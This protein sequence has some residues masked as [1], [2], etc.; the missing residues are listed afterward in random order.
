MQPYHLIIA[1][2]TAVSPVRPQA[3]LTRDRR[4]GG[5]RWSDSFLRHGARS[6]TDSSAVAI[7]PGLQGLAQITKKMPPIC[8]LRGVWCTL[9]HRIGI[10]AGPV[11]G[12]ELDPTMAP[13]PARE[14]AGLAVGQQVDGPVALQIDQYGSVVMAA[15]PCPV[16]D[17]QHAR[18][19][20]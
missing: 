11:T 4:C 3:F 17:S 12:D 15:P 2:P 9:A 16:I 14:R 10:G 8:H 13:Q 19:W 6:L 7:H 1:L 18:R 20:R 5:R